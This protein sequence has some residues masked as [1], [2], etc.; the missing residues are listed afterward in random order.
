MFD[1]FEAEYNVETDNALKDKD[2]IE[3]DDDEDDSFE[4]VN[5]TLANLDKVNEEV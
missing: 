1:H 3:S 5:D 4:N 2:H